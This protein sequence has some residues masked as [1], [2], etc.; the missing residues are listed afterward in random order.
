MKLLKRVIVVF[1][2]IITACSGEMKVELPEHIAA[3]NNLTVYDLPETPTH[4]ITFVP[5]AYF[6]DSDDVL[7]GNFNSAVADDEGRVY[8]ADSDQKTIH[9][10][11]PDGTYIQS[12]GKEGKGP[13]E[14]VNISLLQTDGTYLYANDFSQRRVNVLSLENL[15]F[16]HTI[17]LMKEDNSIDELRGTYP[18]SYN[19]L[20]DGKL[21]VTYSRPYR[22]SDLDDERMNVYYKLDQEGN[23]EPGKI[24]ELKSNDAITYQVNNSFTVW[25]SPFGGR[26]LIATSLGGRIYTAW[27]KDFLISV[28]NPDGEQTAAWYYPFENAPLSRDEALNIYDSDQYRKAV[29]RIVIPPAW[30]ALNRIFTDDQNRLWVSAIVEDQ[31]S[32]QWWVLA[33][34]GEP[35]ATFT[36]PR[37]RSIADIKNGYLYARET[38]EMGLAKVARYRV[39]GL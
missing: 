22:S 5:E 14:F 4:E 25:F 34:N 15:E 3:I 19:L 9:V 13:G 12:I 24:L 20:P 32:Y 6:G 39:E 38:D 11:Q 33:D 30:P 16:S 26:P 7:I 37:T 10:F 28:H 17:P 18:G 36:W 27:S 31:E 2:C 8:L 23:I 35:L 21:L 1:A 29:S